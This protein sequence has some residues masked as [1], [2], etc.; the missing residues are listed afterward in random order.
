MSLKYVQSITQYQA[1]AGG[2]IGATSIVLQD[3][4]DIYGNV[5]TMSDFAD[6][7][8]GSCEPDSVNEESFTFTGVSANANGTYTLTGVSTALAVSPYTETSGLVRGHAGGTKVVISDTTA[9]WNTFANKTN[10]ET[11]TGQWTFDVFPITPSNSDASTTVKGVTKLSVAPASATSPIAVGTNDNRVLVGYAVDSVGTDSYA[12]TPSPAIT[13]YAA[14]QVF[15]FK[16]GT[17]NTGAATLNVSGLGAKTIK[18]NVSVD[19]ETGNILANQIVVVEYDGTNMQLLST[20]ALVS[21]SVGAA[22]AGK[23][24]ELN[25]SGILD[26]TIV[27]YKTNGGGTTHSMS[28]ATSTTIAHGLGLTPSLVK[29]TGT[30]VGGNADSTTFASAVYNGSAQASVNMITSTGSGT[31]EDAGQNFRFYNS[32]T[33]ASDY[34]TGAITVDGT[35]ITIAWT[36]T[37]SPT[38]T[39]NLIWE[40]YQ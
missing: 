32:A 30:A 5:L 15:T 36:L 10:D 19:L 7:G 21:T 33:I 29:I 2:V 8:Y 18:K 38:G 6:K 37:G 1:G 20:A 31:V 12:I 28:S 11:I 40:A 9:F 23:L 27:G 22:D 17:A 4:T 39:A 3:F 26:K 13:A 35:N 25:A 14:G 16:A 34:I 24:P